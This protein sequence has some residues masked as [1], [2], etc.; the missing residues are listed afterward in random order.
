MPLLARRAREGLP[1]EQDS[2]AHGD[3]SRRPHFPLMVRSSL[4]FLKANERNKKTKNNI[5]SPSVC[6]GAPMLCA[7]RSYMKIQGVML[8]YGI[9]E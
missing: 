6:E 9:L 1:D 4:D 8:C 7:E 3:D 5:A 2:D